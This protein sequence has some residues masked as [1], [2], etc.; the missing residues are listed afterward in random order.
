MEGAGEEAG[1]RQTQLQFRQAGGD[2][3]YR[4]RAGQPEHAQGGS[5]DQ[6]DERTG[7]Q[8]RQPLRPED[9]CRERRRADGESAA[10]QVRHG[11]R[12]RPHRTHWPARRHGRAEEGEDLDQHDDDAD[13][14]HEPGDHG[15]R[16][17]H[18]EPARPQQA[19]RHLQNSGQHDDREGL[20]QRRSVR[21][22]DDRHGDGHGGRGTGDLEPVAAEYGRE[23]A[24]G[25][26]AVQA[27][28]GPEP[29][30]DAEG[31]RHGQRDHRRRDAAENVSAQRLQVVFHGRH[32]SRIRHLP[33]GA[34]LWTAPR[35]SATVEG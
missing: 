10:V 6:S 29:R 3:A 33:S 24:D 7:E 1:G 26:R 32:V 2:R 23:E 20:A 9:A 34:L 25:D 4:R 22:H 31:Q 21:R 27:R 8:A 13:P 17:V 35:P 5:G 11:F 12:E 18:D 30:G 16:R 14:R 15:I 28:G 19:E